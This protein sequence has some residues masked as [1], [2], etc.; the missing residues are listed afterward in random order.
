MMIL[1]IMD[2]CHNNHLKFNLFEERSVSMMDSRISDAGV[3]GEYNLSIIKAW[4]F[5]LVANKNT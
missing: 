5:T 2:E 4:D 3:F 1:K